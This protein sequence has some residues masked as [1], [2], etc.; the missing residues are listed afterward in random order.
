MGGL[1]GEKTETDFKIIKFL[2]FLVF[3]ETKKTLEKSTLEVDI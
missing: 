2:L 3:G 1:V